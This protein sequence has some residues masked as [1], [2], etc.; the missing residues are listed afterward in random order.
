MVQDRLSVPHTSMRHHVFY[1]LEKGITL[2]NELLNKRGK[3][4][5]FTFGAPIPPEMFDGDPVE[6]TNALREHA[7]YGVPAG[8]PWV[9][10]EAR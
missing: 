9:R 2:F 4:F 7:S 5:H 1:I 10:P 6:T 8:K 3:P